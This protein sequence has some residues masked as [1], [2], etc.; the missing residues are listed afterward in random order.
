[1]RQI[2]FIMVFL[3]SSLN[4]QEIVSLLKSVEN[5]HLLHM[6]YKNKTFVC[7]PYGVETI[8]QLIE[9]AKKDSLCAK[10]L[11]KFRINHPKE[12]S[13]AKSFLHVEQFYS[14]EGVQNGC[15]LYISS[16]YSYSEVLLEKGYARIPPDFN[17]EDDVQAY[18]FKQAMKRAK[19][20]KVG[21]WSD[22]NVKNCFLLPKKK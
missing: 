9:N 8:S 3:L 19:N 14:V 22:I 21:M 12:K 20:K 17:Y 6:T 16:N 11:Y 7:K 10:Y 4:A 13:F 1:M 15:F 5:N 18:K 2:L